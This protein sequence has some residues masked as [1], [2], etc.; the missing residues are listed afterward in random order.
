MLLLCR[1]QTYSYTADG[2]RV[3]AY[4]TDNYVNKWWVQ[5][6]FHHAVYSSMNRGYFKNPTYGDTSLHATAKPSRTGATFAYDPS[7]TQ[8]SI[9]NQVPVAAADSIFNFD[10]QGM[11]DFVPYGVYGY[12][13]TAPEYSF[14]WN[15]LDMEPMAVPYAP[16]RVQCR[17]DTNEGAQLVFTPS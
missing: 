8:R 16:D 5:D 12:N 11:Q 4:T 9:A 1:Y 13:N 7:S 6:T 17:Y 3:W 10:M 2:S 15:D 14:W